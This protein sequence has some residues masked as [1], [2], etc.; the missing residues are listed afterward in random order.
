MAGKVDFSCLASRFPCDNNSIWNA[1]GGLGLFV[2][3]TTFNCAIMRNFSQVYIQEKRYDVFTPIS[4]VH[5][6]DAMAPLDSALM[7]V[8]TL[9]ACFFYSKQPVCMERTLWTSV[10]GKEEFLHQP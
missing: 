7:G 5:Q 2:S 4:D 10:L 6:A 1:A 3:D 8:S 9:Q